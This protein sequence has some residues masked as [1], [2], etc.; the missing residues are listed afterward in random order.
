MRRIRESFEEQIEQVQ[1]D[2]TR[3]ASFV[4]EMVSDAIRALVDQDEEL[5]DKVIRDDDVADELDLH[6]EQ[7]CMRLLALQQPMAK[8][9]RIIGTA[10][11][12]ISDFER[13]GDYAVDIARS[14]KTLA[15]EPYFK[16]LVDI[17]HMA[18]ITIR[19]VRMAAQAFVN[20]DLN[21]VHQVIEQDEEVDRIWYHLLDELVD[22]MR[23]DPELILQSTHLL[24]VARYLERI[25]DHVVNV[26]ERVSYM[27][28]GRFEDLAIS[29]GMGA[30]DQ[31]TSPTGPCG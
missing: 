13:V 27:E 21:L 19:M 1:V 8:D 3:L 12:I 18:E 2:V 5:A 25:A 7:E 4:V 9:L 23:R 28:T 20:A 26:V 15:D 29:H 14:A 10:L 6:I 22:Y 31:D 30:A 24:L 17:P 11:K 16:A